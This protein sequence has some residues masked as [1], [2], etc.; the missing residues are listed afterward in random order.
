LRRHV[1]RRCNPFGSGHID[2]VIRKHNWR[3]VA[4]HPSL[5]GRPSSLGSFAVASGIGEN[6]RRNALC[7]LPTFSFIVRG[8]RR[9]RNGRK[10]PDRRGI[11]L[12]FMQTVT[13]TT[14]RF[15]MFI[16]AII[17]RTIVIVAR[18]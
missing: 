6:S 18:R 7:H 16:A 10:I 5:F 2:V 11:A 13:E 9:M 1:R 14:R 8:V 3:L 15:W 12:E 17:H 4:V